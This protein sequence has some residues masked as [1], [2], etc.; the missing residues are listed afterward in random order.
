MTEQIDFLAVD[1]RYEKYRI[2]DP[3]AEQ[4]LLARISER[5]IEEPLRGVGDSSRMILLDGFKRYRCAKRLRLGLVPWESVG[6]DEAEG[7]LSVLKPMEHK[8]LGI[9]EQAEYLRALQKMHGMSLGAIAASLSRSRGWVSMRLTL[10]DGMRERVRE[11]IFAGAFPA[12]AYMH[13]VRPFMRMNGGSAE[14]IESFVEAVSGRKLT[15]REIERLAHGYFRGSAAL[16]EE[17][18]AGHFALVLGEMRQVESESGL[19]E[20]ERAYLGELRRLAR[21][22]QL[23]SAGEADPRLSSDA[24]CAQ[25]HLVLTEVLGRMG[26]H[27]R[28]LRRIHDRC[29]CT[30][31]RGSP[32]RVGD[33]RTGDRS[34]PGSQPADGTEDHREQR[35]DAGSAPG[36]AGSDR[37]GASQAPVRGMRGSAAARA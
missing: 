6:V 37:S 4:A 34:S 15:V 7:I 29:G 26:G 2:R 5:G 20:R 30:Q 17:I 13:V 3:S 19:S 22:L 16:R 35:R 9:L 21:S 28:S 32:A 36:G 10:L 1:T 14:A 8:P 12:Y 24:F 25:A 27:V 23:L 11:R 33:E 31:G 18:E